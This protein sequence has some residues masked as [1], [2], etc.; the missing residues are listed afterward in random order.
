MRSRFLDTNI[1]IRYFTKDD[2]AKARQAL[3]LLQR[4][5]RGE[6]QIQTSTIVIFETVYVLR[7][8]YHVPKPKIRELVGNLIRLRG[9]HLPGKY[10][11]LDVL[12]LFVERNISF[13]DA[14]NALYMRAQEIPEIYSWDT[15]FDKL[16][17][18]TRIE[19]QE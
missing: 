18:I 19:P 10:L 7:S 9:L 11:C 12:D 1:L 15:D 16:E 3:A 2:E 6:E 13:A 5:E 17:G 14:Y 4:V 8:I